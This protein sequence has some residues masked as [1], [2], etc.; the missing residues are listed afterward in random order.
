MKEII[1]IADKLIKKGFIEKY[2]IGGSMG[3][4]FYT[5]AFSTKD[6]DVFILPIESPSLILNLEPMYK[7]LKKIGY[8]ME[9]QYFI[10]GGIPVEFAPV[11]NELTLEALKHS[12]KKKYED[13]KVNVLRAE[14]LMVI[15]LQ[16]GRRQD[17]RKI[18]LLLEE[19]SVDKR[20][21]SD[22]LRRYNLEGKWRRYVK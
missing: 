7:Y 8:K 21:L 17:F 5:E 3:V 15:A 19:S 10:I 22:I 6:L 20:L 2:A 13:M 16:T 18:D 1:E 14:Y 4:M 11:Y 9:G 12:V